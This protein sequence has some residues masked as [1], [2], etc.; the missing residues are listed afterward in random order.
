MEFV[1]EK[2]LFLWPEA[3]VGLNQFWMCFN[4]PIEQVAK[5]KKISTL[6]IYIVLSGTVFRVE[7]RGFPVARSNIRKQSRCQFQM[8]ADNLIN[9]R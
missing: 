6:V 1:K 3:Y 5:P 4:H 9:L 7:S 2:G 8:P